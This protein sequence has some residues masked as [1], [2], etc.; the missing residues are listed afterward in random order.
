MTALSPYTRNMPQTAIY[1]PPGV[2]DGLGGVSYGQAVEVRC[3]WQDV[4]VLF[5]SPAGE[6]L[7]SSAVV[8][9]DRALEVK[10]M[11]ALS[12]FEEDASYSAPADVDGSREIRQVATSPSLGGRQ[13]LN[14]VFL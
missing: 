4:A 14:K 2:P 1:W 5:R 3:R 10:G 6:E 8:Y 9:V 7:T 12:S 13:Q 11:I